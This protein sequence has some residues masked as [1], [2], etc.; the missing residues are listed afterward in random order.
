MTEP[1]QDKLLAG[2]VV[3]LG[4]GGHIPEDEHNYESWVISCDDDHDFDGVSVSEFVRDWRVAGA[5][6]EKCESIHAV[7][8]GGNKGQVPRVW[9]SVEDGAPQVELDGPLSRA[10]IEACVEEL[11]RV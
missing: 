4:V 7:V 9:A 10:I 1:N 5:L 2:K 6:I 8:I 11:E 3:A